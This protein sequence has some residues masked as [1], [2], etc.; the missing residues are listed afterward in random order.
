MAEI[1][2]GTMDSADAAV[3]GG[4]TEDLWKTR[5]GSAERK[6]TSGGRRVQRAERARR[7]W[8]TSRSCVVVKVSK[9]NVFNGKS[10][11]SSL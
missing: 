8:P 11:T 6:E 5:G 1:L 2:D 10:L 3:E 9:R 7:T 4:A